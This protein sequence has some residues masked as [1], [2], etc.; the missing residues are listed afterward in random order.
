MPL[1][2][3]VADLKAIPSKNTVT[4]LSDLN[5][6]FPYPANDVQRAM[7]RYVEYN[8]KHCWSAIRAIETGNV[9][10]LAN[11][12]VSAQNL[13]DSSAIDVS[14]IELKSPKLH[15][16]M[17]H[18]ELKAASLAIKGVGS[19]GDGSIQVLCSN[20][21]N[22]VRV[23]QILKDLGCEPFILTVPSSS[24]SSSSCCSNKFDKIDTI[25]KPILL[26]KFKVRK[27]I[28]FVDPLAFTRYHFIAANTTPCLI[29][30]PF[31]NGSNNLFI[32]FLTTH[33]S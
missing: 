6:C 12:M 23:I 7:H 9:N 16:L 27:A 20:E 24:Y 28:L 8:Q 15:K 13:F 22:Q 32:Y 33:P 5:T 29:N 11:A 21:Q 30:L 19:Q 3:V 26:H 31:K 10:G 1:H 17:H 4:I 14:P 18:P 25:E 2:F